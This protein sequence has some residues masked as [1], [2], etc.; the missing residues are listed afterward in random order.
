MSEK[1]VVVVGSS[2]TVGLE[3]VE[4]LNRVEGIK[5]LTLGSTDTQE[6]RNI[7]LALADLAVLCLPEAAAIEFVE[8]APAT[9]RILDASPAHRTAPGWLYGLAEL[10]VANRIRDHPRVANPGCYATGAVLLLHPIMAAMP[11]RKD[12]QVAITAIGGV[13]S[14]GRRMIEKEKSAPIDYRL[15]GLNQDHRHIPEIKHYAGLHSEPIFMPAV[16]GHH[17]GT[18]VQIPFSAAHLGLGSDQVFSLLA[19]AY[20]NCPRVKVVPAAEGQRYLSAD[21]MAGSDDVILHVLADATGTRMVLVAQ[22]DNLGIGAAGAAEYNVKL[23]LGLDTER[24]AQP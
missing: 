22:F 14:G 11:E 24:A 16:T 9:L 10:G 15:Y 3:M 18:V 17:R 5:V 7:V 20:E 4:R 12:L 8:S 23:M 19:K 6:M 13:S 2:G 21:D 1:I